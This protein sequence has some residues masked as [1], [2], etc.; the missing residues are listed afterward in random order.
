MNDDR[1][2]ALAFAVFILA[3]AAAAIGG[4]RLAQDRILASQLGRRAGEAAVEAAAAVVADAVVAGIAADEPSVVD[5]ARAAATD[6]AGRNG[7]ARIEALVVACGP[8]WTEV[9]M[10]A[11]GAAERAAID[12]TCS[13]R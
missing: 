9:R 2:Q 3:L 6:I 12:V 5:R 1:G 4:L 7:G 8:R 10:N 11:G 13:P